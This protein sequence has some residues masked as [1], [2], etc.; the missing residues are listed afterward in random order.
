MSL[1]LLGKKLGMT[2]LFDAATQSMIPVTVIEVSGNTC[3][4]V[5]TLENDGYSAVQVGYGD[6]KES[7]VDKPSL[8]HFKKH[9]STPKYL[10]QEFRF[11]ANQAAPATHPGLE[12]FTAGQWVDVIGTSKGRGFQGAVK[13]H[14]FGGLKM[15]H[16]S[17]M[18]RRTGAIGCRSTP[19]RVWKNQKMPGHM[20]DVPRTVQNLKVVAVRPEDGVILISGAV[21][22]S[23]GGFVTIRP[24]KKKTAAA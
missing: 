3:L 24:A 9:G 10:I 18:H 2:R 16:G 4:Q 22:G 21:P 23:K 19:G 6:K 13:R 5:K 12:T 17:M 15:T 14:G 7:R 8:G 20:G 1:G 11:E